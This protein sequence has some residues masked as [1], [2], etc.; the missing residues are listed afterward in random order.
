MN[1]PI[2][3]T[4]WIE[5]GKIIGG[6]YP[7]TPKPGEAR[8]IREKL[9]AMGVRVFV[10]LQEPGE[11]GEYGT[12]FPDYE[13]EVETIARDQ[14]VE[15]EFHRFPI[16]D[17]HAPTGEVMSQVLQVLHAA[18][19]AGKLTYV[20]CWGGHG[21]TGTVAGCWMVE[22]RLTAK[23][24]FALITERRKHDPHLAVNPAPQTSAQVALVRSWKPR[25][26]LPKIAVGDKPVQPTSD[27]ADRMRGAL[28]GLAVGD[29]L[30]TTIEF[31]PPGSFVPVQDIV[32]GGPF[33]LEPGQWTDDTS[34]ALCLAESLVERG[35]FDPVDQLARYVK[36]WK[37][38][39]LSS[40]GNCFDIGNQ[41][42]TALGDHQAP[43]P[44]GPRPGNRAVD[45]AL[46]R[47]GAY[48][49]LGAGTGGAGAHGDFQAGQRLG[50][51]PA[52]GGGRSDR[53]G[54]PTQAGPGALW[55]RLR[56]DPSAFW[57][58]PVAPGLLLLPRG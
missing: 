21:R 2:Q 17:N 3:K 40:T 47:S 36:W 26:E 41:T 28:I 34:M 50:G 9:V 25:T 1:L 52:A 8:R 29:A 20:H 53:R 31:K 14:G 12:P 16:R 43:N 10:N 44:A 32:G 56:R 6:R 15:V 51:L 4:W 55:T 7:G 24:A 39:H 58:L 18:V 49:H 57:R 23:Q 38:G 48:W 11:L 35:C 5:P 33:G 13:T 42:R 45:G 54:L 19:D 37:H 22:K 27:L 30:G 46:C